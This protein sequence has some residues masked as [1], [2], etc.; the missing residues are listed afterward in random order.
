MEQIGR[1]K[2]K[3]GLLLDGTVTSAWIER[4]VQLIR[5]SENLEIRLAVVNA[6]GAEWRVAGA[7][8]RL[9]QEHILYRIYMQYERILAQ[10]RPDAFEQKDLKPLLE[11]VPRLEVASTRLG[12][13]E[14]LDEDAQQ[15]EALGLDV[16]VKLGFGELRGR[17]LTAARYGVWALRYGDE[18]TLRIGPPG[19][20]EVFEGRVIT[21]SRLEIVGE[22][23]EQAL[24]IHRTWTATAPLSVSR[25]RHNVIWKTLHL[26]L[27]SL[28]ELG[29]MGGEPFMEKVRRANA[30]GSFYFHKHYSTPSNREF[31]M[32]PIKQLF[33]YIWHRLREGL[34]FDQWFIM[35]SMEPETP[36]RDLRRYNRIMPPEGKFWADPF[37]Y[38]RDGRYYIFFEELPL[39]TDKGYIAVVTQDGKGGWTPP[40]PALECPYHLSYPF[41]F[42]WEGETYMLPETI[43]NHSVELYRCTGWPD[44]WEFAKTLIHDIRAVDSTLFEHNG[45]WWLLSNVKES[46]EIA[47]TDEMCVYYADSPVSDHWTP[48]P[49]NPVVSDVRSTRPGGR[50]FTVNGT[51]YRPAQNDSPDYGKGM[52]I[53]KIVRLDEEVYEEV[54]VERLEP[55]WN[56]ELTGMHTLN[57]TEGMTVIDV[58]R[59]RPSF[60]KLEKLKKLFGLKSKAGAQVPAH[61]KPAVPVEMV[62]AVAKVPA[63]VSAE[64]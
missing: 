31:L 63:P 21:G 52:S 44:K 58:R 47:D 53:N 43:G 17:V 51:I 36:A 5:N 49:Q 8:E 18:N 38:K 35:Y 12:E 25:N 42:D 16:L 3:V 9:E 13:F 62:D 24:V 59:R 41:I 26:A 30:A 22:T 29:R 64:K 33:R 11:G 57:F 10:P 20:W 60:H 45:K 46:E 37:V 61:G 6:R 34:S 28:S 7:E 40:V 15:I 4:L 19:F 32:F 55:L 48:H 1:E 23:T 56:R 14:Y 27:R 54:V 39:A 50:L 2:V